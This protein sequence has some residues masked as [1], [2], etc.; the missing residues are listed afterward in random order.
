M[1]FPL[2][3]VLLGFA[4]GAAAGWVA[5]LLRTPTRAPEG[6]GADEAMHLPQEEF[7]TPPELADETIDLTAADVAQEPT[8][9]AEV[10][11]AAT[12][13]PDEPHEHRPPRKATAPAVKRP[14]GS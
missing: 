13:S 12:E 10:I 4:A 2:R 3:R 9:P 14:P 7:G 8:A 5:G 11:E 6:S 1:R